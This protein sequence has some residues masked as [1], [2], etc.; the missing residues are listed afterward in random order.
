MKR[1]VITIALLIASIT[2]YSQGSYKLDQKNGFNKFILGTDLQ[3]NKKLGKLSRL[4]MNVKSDVLE[5]YEVTRINDIKLFGYDLGSISLLFYKDKLLQIT[6]NLKNYE[7][8]S[9]D[10]LGLI[11]IDISNKIGEEY[12]SWG[13]LNLMG[14]DIVNNVHFKR[15]ILGS[16]VTLYRYAYNGTRIADFRTVWQGDRYLFISNEVYNRMQAEQGDSS[17]L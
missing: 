1:F 3:Y 7:I 16:K 13:D 15:S 6:V 10:N 11:S 14:E 4:K 2:T 5:L 8:P 17:G 12:G 9:D